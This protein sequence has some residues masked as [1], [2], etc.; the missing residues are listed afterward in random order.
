MFTQGLTFLFVHDLSCHPQ[1][2]YHWVTDCIYFNTVSIILICCQV[3]FAQGGVVYV[4]LYL[5]YVK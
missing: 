5:I 1:L 2:S 4:S 3:E